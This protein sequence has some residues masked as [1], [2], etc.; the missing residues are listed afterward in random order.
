MAAHEAQESGSKLQGARNHLTCMSRALARPFWCWTIAVFLVCAGQAGAFAEPIH[1]RQAEGFLHGFLVVRNPEGRILADGDLLQTVEGDRVTARL[2]F[3]FKD[4]SVDDETTVFSQNG[5]FRLIA[6]R[7]I[8]KGP[9]FPHP[10]DMSIDATKGEV[11]VR[12]MGKD[13]KEQVKQE[14]LD[15]PLDLVNGMVGLAIRN[16]RPDAPDTTLPMLVA[17]PEPRLVNLV[18]SPRGGAPFSLAGFPRKALQFDI[19]IDLGGVAGFI[20]PLIG[21][22]PPDLHIWILGGDVPVFLKEE[23]P[24]YAEGPIWTLALVS[25]VWKP[26][27]RS[28]P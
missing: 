21:K 14:H 13:G 22:Q 17:T 3:H 9:S 6:D 18:I 16:M 8:Q 24:F 26:A 25:P 28:K 19:K 23:G 4:G 7:H 20:A 10:M 1:V 11:T 15:L 27:R 12:S 5:T 2:L